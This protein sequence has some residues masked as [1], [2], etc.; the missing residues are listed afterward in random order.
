METSLQRPVQEVSRQ[1]AKSSGKWKLITASILIFI[2]ILAAAVAYYQ[3]TRFNANVSI[4]GVMVNGLTAEQALDELK[5]ATL[6]N[7]VYIGQQQI[8]DGKDTK[9]GFA[10]E[11]LSGVKEI[12]NNQQTYIPSFKKKDYSL[13]PGNP[14][15]F[16]SHE[17]KKQ[18]EDKL[19][20]MNKSLQAP[21]DADVVL[22]EGK[23]TVLNSAAGKQYD[24]AG[25]LKEYDQ[26]AYSSEV[27]LN[28]V[29]FQP[30][31][32]D[33]AIIKNKEQRLQAL[34]QQTIDYKVQDQTYALKA[35]DLIKSAT[36][37]NDMKITF[38]QE[39]LKNKLTEINN[40][41]STLNKDFKFKTHSGSVITI[42]GKGYG[43][44]LDVE[45]EAARMMEAFEKGEKSVSASNIHGNGW[46]NEGYGYETTAN[47]GIGNTY[48]E[49]SIK[50][51]RIWVYKNGK[52]VVT[53]NVVTGNHNTREDTSPGVWYILFKKSPSI[54]KGSRVGSGEYAV[55]V[56][57]WVPFTNSGQGIHD[58]SWR[59]NWSSNAYIGAGSGGCV[60]VPPSVMKAIYTN[61]TTYDP[62]VVY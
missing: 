31:K 43:W 50:E 6:K 58:A 34:L 16:R 57:Y 10:D 59:S 38:D 30:I 49:V 45:K 3:T 62:V 17:L 41:Q 60:N 21:K 28:P 11:D 35:S 32:E 55:P 46:N 26:Q 12:F 22:K 29:Y 19:L 25:L 14:D 20:T 15:A 24:V 61:L 44:A 47:N 53:T 13:N 42:K 54:L 52:L 33:S 5:T 18:L 2:G 36:V 23:I 51:Q 56:N 48:A 4:N 27:R 7:V 39:D 37:S 40:T 9:I 1:K 8:I